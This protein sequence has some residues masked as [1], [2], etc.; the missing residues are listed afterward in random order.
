MKKVLVVDD[1]EQIVN[2]LKIFLT[3]R[4]YNVFTA[5]DGP[6]AINRINEVGPSVVL[7]DI[8]MPGMNGIDALVKIRDIDRNVRVVMMSALAESELI[9]KALQLGACDYVIKPFDLGYIDTVIAVKI[10]NLSDKLEARR[11]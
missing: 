5:P 10:A 7:L 4:G 3:T 9:K 11:I 2:A 8:V 1:E 6:T